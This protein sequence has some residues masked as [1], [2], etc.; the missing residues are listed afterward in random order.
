MTSAASSASPVTRILALATVSLA[1]HPN[2]PWPVKPPRAA[3]LSRED[4]RQ[5]LKIAEESTAFS[6]WEKKFCDSLQKQ[7]RGGRD[8]SEAQYS[9]LNRGLLRRLWDNDPELWRNV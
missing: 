6:E 3:E 5:F 8:V 1:G 2:D 7:L 4:L 9:V